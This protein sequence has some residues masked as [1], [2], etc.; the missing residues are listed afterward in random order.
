[1]PINDKLFTDEEFPVLYVEK[2]FSAHYP[3]NTLIRWAVLE[4][5]CN[6]ENNILYRAYSPVTFIKFAFKRI[7][8]KAIGL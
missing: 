2:A 3:A 4:K 6:E 5:T 8:A 7:V 1:M